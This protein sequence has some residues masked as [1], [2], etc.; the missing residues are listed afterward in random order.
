MKERG[1]VKMSDCRWGRGGFRSSPRSKLHGSWILNQV[2]WFQLRLPYLWSR[3]IR[4]ER[5]WEVSKQRDGVQKLKR[6]DVSFWR[7]GLIL[8]D[9]GLHIPN[10]SI[11]TSR[12]ESINLWRGCT[13]SLIH[14]MR[15]VQD[16]LNKNNRGTSPSIS[17]TDGMNGKR[18]SCLLM[19]IEWERNAC[20]FMALEYLIAHLWTA[21]R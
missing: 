8:S 15:R 6:I 18:W 7:S 2:E 19:S 13:G 21:S 10:A 3:A 17:L 12:G 14:C 1:R 11:K 5:M 20:C 16:I 9:S 4:G